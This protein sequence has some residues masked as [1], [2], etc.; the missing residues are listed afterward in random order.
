MLAHQTLVM[1]LGYDPS[2]V[3]TA[4]LPVNQPQVSFAYTKLLW[5]SG[6]RKF[7]YQQLTS[8]LHN[9]TCKCNNDDVTPED[10]QRLLAR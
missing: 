1:L 6:N 5:V 9:Y 8:F 4:D 2:R 10:R 7:A 3:P